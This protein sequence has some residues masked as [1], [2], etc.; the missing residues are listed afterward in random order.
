MF[1]ELFSCL[2][3]PDDEFQ[4][5]IVFPALVTIGVGQAVNK[6]LFE[7][8]PWLATWPKFSAGRAKSEEECSLLFA[9]Q[10]LTHPTLLRAIHVLARR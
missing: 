3:S 2:E 4:L 8:C 5:S 7:G 1:P 9:D 10:Q 6:K